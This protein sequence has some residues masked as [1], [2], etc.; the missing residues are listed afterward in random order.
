MGLM[1]ACLLKPTAAAPS[2]GV[3]C[4]RNVDIQRCGSDHGRTSLLSPALMLKCTAFG[5]HP[6]KGEAQ[7]GRTYP[8]RGSQASHDWR[9][10]G[11]RHYSFL[12][13]DW[14]GP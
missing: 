5:K 6:H 2:T 7:A 8:G 11:D 3:G 9:P 10:Q 1:P 12:S 4:L 14:P 13:P